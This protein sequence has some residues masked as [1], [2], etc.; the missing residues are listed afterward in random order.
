[1]F[2]PIQ[3]Q[4]NTARLALIDVCIQASV[5]P[6]AMLLYAQ[7][8]CFQVAI[9]QANLKLN[10]SLTN[11]ATLGS[12]VKDALYYVI[13]TLHASVIRLLDALDAMRKVDVIHVLQT[14]HDVKVCVYALGQFARFQLLFAF[15]KLEQV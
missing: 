9:T 7:V 1:M 13:I 10:M 4:L 5:L 8:F 11:Y 3:G 6:F 2:L 12:L 14:S 15:Q